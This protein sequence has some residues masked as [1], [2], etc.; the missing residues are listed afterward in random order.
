MTSMHNGIYSENTS[1]RPSLMTA[2]SPRRSSHRRVYSSCRY[3][4][5]I[6]R[7]WNNTN[8]CSTQSNNKLHSIPLH[9]TIPMRNNYNKLHLS[10]PNRL[11]IPNRILFRKSYSPCDRSSTNP[12]PMKLH[13]SYCSN[14]STRLNVICTIL[15]SQLQL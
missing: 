4:A 11:K 13:R 6:R 2:Q 1:V 9:N 8:H 12:D 5:K 15:P 3:S 14:S 7:L 10:T